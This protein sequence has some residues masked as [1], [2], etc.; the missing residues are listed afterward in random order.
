MMNPQSL[1]RYSYCLNNPLTYTDPT[2]HW[3]WPSWNTVL[4]AV[5]VVVVVA[6]ATAL[7]VATVGAAAPAL[8]AVGGVVIG[9]TTALT[10]VEIAEV[11]IAAGTIAGAAY[12]AK[13]SDADDSLPAS[14]ANTDTGG[15]TAGADPNNSGDKSNSK[16]TTVL[17]KYPDYIKLADEIQAN[18][19]NIPIKTWEN[20]STAERWAANQKFLDEAIARGDRIILSNRI[21]DVNDATGTFRQELEYLLENGYKLSDDGLGL[22]KVK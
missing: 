16:R 22:I 19:F 11:S 12:A 9:G 14:K 2:G 5:T 21:L 13:N 10:A 17:G 1:N 6:A 18:R 15:Q 4:K 8:A 3:H 20:M 7:V